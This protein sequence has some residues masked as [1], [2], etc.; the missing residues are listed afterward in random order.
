MSD[1]QTTSEEVA[2]PSPPSVL[3]GPGDDGL[4]V[5]MMHKAGFIRT[6]VADGVETLWRRIQSIAI[7]EFGMAQADADH[8]AHT[9]I[10]NHITAAS[11]PDL[12]S[13]ALQEIELLRGE[14]GQA[15]MKIAEMAGPQKPTAAAE[16]KA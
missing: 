12:H 9:A 1:A 6:F 16:S 15:H 8:L 11:L 13:E 2:G 3:I 4:F 7:A 10:D 14:L 5:G